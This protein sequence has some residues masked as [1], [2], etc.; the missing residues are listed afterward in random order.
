MQ[1]L[2]A[3]P[4]K[5]LAAT[6]PERI[7]PPSAR[8]ERRVV[9]NPPTVVEGRTGDHCV[10]QLLLLNTFHA[11]SRDEFHA[12]SEKPGYDP[13]QRLLIKRQQR[14]AAHLLLT[15]Y[16][17]RVGNA[18]VPTQLLHC[19]PQPLSSAIKAMPHNSAIGTTADASCWYCVWY[20]AYQ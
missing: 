19:W 11:P 9:A 8:R 6:T 2:V 12:W 1:P 18:A 17:V 16:A 5:T 7:A 14:L 4:A 20:V 3:R 15:K 13:G 10:A